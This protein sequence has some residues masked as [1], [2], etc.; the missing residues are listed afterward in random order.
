VSRE[1]VE[2]LRNH[3]HLLPETLAGIRAAFGDNFLQEREL[4]RIPAV[5]NFIR[6]RRKE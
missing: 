2:E 5:A 3:L 6:E 1:F 4:R